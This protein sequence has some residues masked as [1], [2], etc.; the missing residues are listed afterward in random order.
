MMETIEIPAELACFKLPEAVQARL[1]ELLDR[2][3]AG[4]TLTP[5]ER[6]EAEGLV[7][8]AEFLSFLRLRATPTKASAWMPA[9]PASLRR[10]TIA[11]AGDRCEY[12]GLAQVGQAATFHIDHV[13]STAAGGLTISENLALA[14]IS[15]S[16]RK[17]ARQAAPDPESGEDAPLYSPRQQIWG[18]HFRWEGLR[19]VGLTPT[20]RATAA[21]LAMN[22]P[23]ILA[24][25]AEEAR[26]GRH[27]PP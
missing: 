7:E 13:V 10:R 4:Q 22:R 15:C 27:P 21:A 9:I 12:C 6:R 17:G 5:E 14:C 1:Q 26:F 20:G 16:L 23:M 19:V 25:R 2:Q 11:R 24:I 8:L 3:D 18:E